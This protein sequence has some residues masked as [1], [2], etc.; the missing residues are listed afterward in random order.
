[1]SLAARV[2]VFA[3]QGP[4]LS[5]WQYFLLMVQITVATS[6]I[7]HLVSPRRLGRNI[8]YLVAVLWETLHFATLG[9]QARRIWH[10]IS[11]GYELFCGRVLKCPS[12][13]QQRR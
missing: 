5:S 13:Y 10:G 6:L 9:R 8:A 4:L 2:G 3:L 11:A 7:E 12:A 1:M